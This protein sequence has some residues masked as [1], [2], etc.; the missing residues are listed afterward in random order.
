MKKEVIPHTDGTVP[1]PRAVKAGNW[2]SIVA[3][4]IDAKGVVVSADFEAQL[5]FTYGEMKKTLDSLGSSIENI[6]QM[7]IYLVNMERDLP[8]VSAI[9]RKYIPDDKF[10]AVAAIGTTQ[11]APMDP[12]LLLE[13]SCWAIIPDE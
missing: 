2:I 8:K 5:D 13:I 3:A 10:P 7:T 1:W 11:L 4:G 6:V 12:P 9:R